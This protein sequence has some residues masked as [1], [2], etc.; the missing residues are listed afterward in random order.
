MLSNAAVQTVK[1][2]DKVKVDIGVESDGRTAV[3][4]KLSALLASTYMLYLK[5]LYY[6][7]NVTGPNFVGLHQL[8]EQQYQELHAA[9]DSIAERIRALGHFTP[10]TVR[11]FL[12]MASVKDDSSLPQPAAR[13]IKSLLEDNELC[14]KEARSVLE[15]AK[16]AED[17]VTVDMMIE[18]MTHHDKAAWMLRA[19]LE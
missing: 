19:A 5:S 15:V 11:E 4:K 8:F 14:S 16:E 1:K 12:A 10:G 6:H 18:R 13:M 9:G 17:E 7:W 2:E 3:S